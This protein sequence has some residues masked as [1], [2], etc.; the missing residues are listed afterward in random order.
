MVSLFDFKANRK[1][2]QE[3]TAKEKLCLPAIPKSTLQERLVVASM[4]TTKGHEFRKLQFG[5]KSKTSGQVI[6]N[7]V[8][9]QWKLA[10]T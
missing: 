4:P 8:P 3:P 5:G 2:P 1:F 6:N 10:E 9:Q 7:H